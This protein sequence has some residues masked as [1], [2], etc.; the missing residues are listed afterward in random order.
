MRACENQIVLDGI[1]CCESDYK[2]CTDGQPSKKDPMLLLGC[3]DCNEPINGTKWAD[4]L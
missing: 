4:V 3:G 1:I 2:P